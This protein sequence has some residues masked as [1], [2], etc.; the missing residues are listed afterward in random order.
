[1]G[2]YISVILVDRAGRKF[3][4]IISSIFCTLGLSMFVVYDY[5]KVVLNIDVSDYNWIPLASFSVVIL[6]A[7]FGELSRHYLILA[8]V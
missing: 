2:V 3:L 7:N 8:P 4:L 1:V 5:M 6:F